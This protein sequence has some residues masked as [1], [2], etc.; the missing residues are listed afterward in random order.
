MRLGDGRLADGRFAGGIRAAVLAGL[1]AI[2]MT[3]VA[4]PAGAAGYT[5]GYKFLEAVKK[6][7]LTEVNKFLQKPGNTI[8]KAAD[9]T[10]GDTALHIVTRARSVPWINLM[11]QA[12]ADVNARNNAGLSPLQ[13]AASANFLDGVEVLL[14]HKARVDDPD[15]SGETPLIGAV[16]TH[17]LQLVRL[18]L[19]NGADPD[20][21]DNSGRSARDYARLDTQNGA[22]ILAALTSAKAKNGQTPGKPVYGPSL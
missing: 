3:G 11:V 6:Q 17:N 21:P 7:D 9:F 4:V 1:A 12:G 15:Q 19:D 16:H 22:S 18:L 14:Y 20:R 2:M 10:T 8:A 13:I 5:D